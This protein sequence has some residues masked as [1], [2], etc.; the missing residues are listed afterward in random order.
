VTQSWWF[1]AGLGFSFLDGELTGSSG[2]IPVGSAN[3]GTE[4]S[5]FASITDDGRSGN[6]VDFD[7]RIGWCNASDRFRVWLGW[8]QSIWSEIAQDPLRNFPGTTA[9]LRERDS[10]AFSGY[11]LGLYFRF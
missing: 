9:P 2:L 8:E 11:K 3:A 1:G 10:V 6:I 7:L 4:P 5:S